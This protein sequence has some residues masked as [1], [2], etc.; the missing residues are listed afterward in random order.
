[1]KQLTIYQKDYCPYCKAAKQLLRKQ[2]FKFRTIEVSNNP[3]AFAQMVKLSNR[4]TVPQIFVDDIH[5]GGFDNLQSNLKRKKF[6]FEHLK[7]A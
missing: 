3:V 4:R 6:P 5:I 7:T 1:M 2:G